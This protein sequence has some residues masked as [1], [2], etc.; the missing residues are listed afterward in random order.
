MAPT[1]QE[2]ETR[3][4]TVNPLEQAYL[5]MKQIADKTTIVFLEQKNEEEKADR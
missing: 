4:N 3:G 5:R 1:G 2:L